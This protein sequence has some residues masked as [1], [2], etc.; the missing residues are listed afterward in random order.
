[1]AS[2]SAVSPSAPV[3]TPEVPR[4]DND[5]ARLAERRLQ[6]GP[7]PVLRNVNCECVEGRLTLSGTVGSY[8]L[9]QIAQTIVSRVPGV[10]L[11]EN[12]LEVLTS[13]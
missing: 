13:R 2:I 11:V 3:A 5:V 1:M 10:E 9:K 12:R 4:S 6:G 8:Y 7:Y